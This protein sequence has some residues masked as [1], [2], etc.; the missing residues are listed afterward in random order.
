MK[1]IV[2]V[3]DSYCAHSKYHTVPPES[4]KS[5]APDQVC[6]PDVV[7][8][9]VERNPVLFGYGGRSWWFSYRR[10]REWQKD[11]P[12]EWADTDTMVFCLTNANRPKITNGIYLKQHHE[13]QHLDTKHIWVEDE[14]DQWC[15]EKYTDEI[16]EWAKT[17]RVVVCF[18]FP[19]EWWIM[20]R[21][22]SHAA[23][24][25]TPLINISRSEIGEARIGV[26]IPD[27][28]NHMND[29][30][31]RALAQQISSKILDYQPGMFELNDSLYQLPYK[32]Q[33]FVQWFYKRARVASI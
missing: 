11:K 33:E 29:H 32:N 3:G 8:D 27:H 28:A 5:Y 14:F 6:W 19:E 13:G 10:L 7:A 4:G 21:L 18:N 17:R 26:H 1:N 31:N 12:N 23:V 16:A 30:N 20:D 9:T 22:K 2:F 25:D 15:Y 24:L